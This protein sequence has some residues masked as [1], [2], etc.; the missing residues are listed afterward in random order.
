[1]RLVSIAGEDDGRFAGCVFG[2]A[3]R[4]LT[5][6]EAL[7]LLAAL[8]ILLGVFLRVCLGFFRRKRQK[9]SPTIE[10]ITRRPHR[11]SGLHRLPAAAGLYSWRQG[12]FSKPE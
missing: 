11:W 4:A 8:A 2:V 7:L 1:M 10:L 3:S 5:G 6:R 9:S 12:L